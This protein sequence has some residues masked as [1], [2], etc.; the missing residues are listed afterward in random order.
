MLCL[1]VDRSAQS[2]VRP[3]IFRMGKSAER[4][5]IMS[6]QRTGKVIFLMGLRVDLETLAQSIQTGKAQGS[7][8]SMTLHS[9]QASL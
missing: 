6:G 1:L 9:A 3:L 7:E 4:I 5:Q 2:G 8:V